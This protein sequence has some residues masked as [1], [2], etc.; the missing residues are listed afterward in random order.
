MHVSRW[1]SLL[2]GTY[3]MVE[4]YVYVWRNGSRIRVLD[5]IGSDWLLGIWNHAYRL[6][7]HG[8]RKVNAT[9]WYV[10][11]KVISNK[12][13]TTWTWFSYVNGVLSILS[14]FGELVMQTTLP[15]RALQWLDVYLERRYSVL[16]NNIC[17]VKTQKHMVTTEL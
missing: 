5:Q 9:V 6:I 13:Y 7:E 17:T 16:Y 15:K 12:L 4:E 2:I 10:N 14:V 11:A 8:Q 3:W 1:D